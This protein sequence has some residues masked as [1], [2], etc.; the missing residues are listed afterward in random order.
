MKDNYS[1]Q[2]KTAL[3]NPYG[4][5]VK[6]LDGDPEKLLVGIKN[7][8]S[9]PNTLMHR[10]EPAGFTLHTIDKKSQLAGRA[11]DTELINPI[12]GRFIRSGYHVLCAWCQ[13]LKC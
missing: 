1:L 6:V 3:L 9:I 10:L 13:S 4:S 8:R 12:S 2:H 11:V 7:V 5:I